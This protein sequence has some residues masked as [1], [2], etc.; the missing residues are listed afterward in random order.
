MKTFRFLISFL[1]IA[2]TTL[3]QSPKD[4]VQI[5]SAKMVSKFIPTGVRVGFDL[6]SLGQGVI[7]NGLPAITQGRVRQWKFNADVDFYRYFLAL[8]YGVFER[9][10]EGLDNTLYNNNGQFLKIGVDVNFLHRDPDQSALFIGMRYATSK[11][12]DNISYDYANAFWGSGSGFAENNSLSSSW[13]ELTTGLK[14]KLKKYF[15]MGYTARFQFNVNDNYASNELAPHWIPGYGL[16]EKA[17]NW[18][19]EYWLIFRIPF[20]EYTP[21]PKKKG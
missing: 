3:A 2:T 5:D 13:F 1:L 11:Y 21:A 17:S 9:Q 20:R 4:S 10:W 14:V 15:W 18:G 12:D 7:K 8:E 19:F 16:A 6:V